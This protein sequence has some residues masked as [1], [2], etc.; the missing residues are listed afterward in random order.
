MI[1][2]EDRFIEILASIADNFTWHIMSKHICAFRKDMLYD[3][4]TACAL[5]IKGEIVPRHQSEVIPALICLKPPL[6]RT[7]MKSLYANDQSDKEAVH[8]RKRMLNAVGL[9]N[10]VD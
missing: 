2:H 6:F 1:H 8:L 4:L 7:I 10:T 5:I 3:P 9:A